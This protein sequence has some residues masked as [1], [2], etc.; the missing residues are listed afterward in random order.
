[1]RKEPL[2]EPQPGAPSFSKY[3][4]RLRKETLIVHCVAL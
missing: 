4:Y 3:K 2:K 1:M